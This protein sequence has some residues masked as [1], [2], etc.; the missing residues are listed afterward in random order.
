MV[1]T[2]TAIFVRADDVLRRRHQPR[3]TITSWRSWVDLITLIV[4]FGIFYGAVI[5]T[6]GG[7]D[8]ERSWHLVYSAVKIPLLLLATFVVSL[9][10]FFVLNS[11]FGLRQDFGDSMRS[12]VAAQ[13]A[14]AIVLASLAPFTMLWYLSSADYQWAILCN[15]VMFTI[16]SLAAQWLLRGY[17]RPLVR[18]NRNHRWMLWSWIVVYALVGIQMGWILRPFIGSPG[19]PV[20]FFR[21]GAWDNAYVIVGRLIWQ[22]IVGS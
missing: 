18:Q 6:F 15:V 5:G 21:T 1:S 19:A 13:A 4:L 11:L 7:L 16:A 3:H 20:Q 10:S 14:L 17:Y 8:V 9:P 22:A 12:L 2:M